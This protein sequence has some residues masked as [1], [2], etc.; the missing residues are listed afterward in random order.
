[1]HRRGTVVPARQGGAMIGSV[2]EAV[3][4]GRREAVCAA[5]T[6][7]N[8][9]L[10]CKRESACGPAH[11]SAGNSFNFAATT[12]QA[13]IRSA[14]ILSSMLSSPSYSPR[15][16][17]SWPFANTPDLRANPESVRQNLE[18]DIA[19]ARSEAAVTQCCQGQRVRR[20]VDQIEAS[21]EGNC[22]VAGILEPGEARPLET[23][24][25][26]RVRWFGHERLARSGQ[27]LKR[28]GHFPIRLPKP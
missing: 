11:F 13:L 10:R 19:I 4:R 17:I 15:L 9:A 26:L 22:G 2:R 12:R 16:R 1:M 7:G 21:V 20:V 28:R 14:T 27:T 5:M 23:R 25:F 6:A 24:E 8:S 3:K 18:H